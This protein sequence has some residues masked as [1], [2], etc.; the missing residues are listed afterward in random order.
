MQKIE[1]GKT[2]K[3]LSGQE[4]GRFVKVVDDNQ[5]TGDY[6]I[7]TSDDAQF[8]GGFKNYDGWVESLKNLEGFFH[9]AN[10]SIEWL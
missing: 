10:W 5:N 3:I 9:E 2:G 8:R 1:I 4:V 6:L 7:L